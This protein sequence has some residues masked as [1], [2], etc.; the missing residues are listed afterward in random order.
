MAQTRERWPATM[1]RA[2]LRLREAEGLTASEIAERL[3]TEHGRKPPASTVSGWLAPARAAAEPPE[4]LAAA[5]RSQAGRILALANRELLRLE[6]A[7]GP[8]DLERLERLARILKSSEGL[9]PTGAPTGK[10]TAVKSLMDLGNG[11]AP[12]AGGLTM[13]STGDGERQSRSEAF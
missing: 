6:R 1:R 4:D 8:C 13:L 5:V 10:V 12:K 7:S 3:G 9:R 11:K 2:A